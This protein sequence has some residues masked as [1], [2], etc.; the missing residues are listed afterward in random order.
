MG[1]R[2]LVAVADS[3]E[4]LMGTVSAGDE[5][6]GLVA[7]GAFS[8]DRGFVAHAEDFIRHDIYMM[9]VVGRFDLALRD[10]FG[11][12]YEKLRDVFSDEDML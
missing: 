4:A 5:A 10:R 9:K 2:G 1:L 11:S 7:S 6:A 8:R 3:S 12:K